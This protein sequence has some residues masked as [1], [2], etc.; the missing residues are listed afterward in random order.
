MPIQI[1]SDEKGFYDRECPNE[2]CLF[3]FKVDLEQWGEKISGRN[4]HCPRC[5]C[6]A[7]HDQ[8]FTQE[9][10]E[11]IQNNALSYAMGYVQD[12]LG[13]AFKSAE[14]KTRHNKYVK[15][16]YKPGPRPVYINL[17]MTQSE[18]WATE[19][20]CDDCGM[21]FSVI[22]NAYFCPC[23][24]KD[25]ITN[26]IHDSLASYRKRIEGMEG[27]R[28]Y[29]EESCSAED[30][31]RQVASLREDT[32]GALVGTFES[33]AK[34]RFVE[35]G[36]T[37][38]KGNVFQR[39]SDGSAQY[40]K[41]TGEGYQEFIGDD[42]VRDMTLLVNRRHLLTHGNG[43]V[44][45]RYLSK[46]GDTSYTVG[47]RIVVKDHDLLRLLEII[48]KLVDGLRSTAAV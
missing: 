40:E 48:E 13:A 28:G 34:N 17:P 12:A 25:L 24:G 10:I 39:I 7:F 30:A 8:W 5:G 38:P 20:V 31:E 6:E 33:F 1:Q 14:R 42:G 18:E 32:L 23:C 44:D 22:G 19:I 9:Q 37:A 15:I 45:E 4:M 41:L 35:L 16:T 21:R 2:E 43:I 36:G 29:F 46:T 11:V 27:L 47:Q 26:A 3:L